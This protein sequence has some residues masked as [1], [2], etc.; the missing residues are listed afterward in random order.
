V[1]SATTTTLPR[2]RGGVL[3]LIASTDH[4]NVAIRIFLTGFFFFVAGGIL[5]LLIRTELYS[6]GQQLVNQDHYNEIFS[7]HGSTMIYLFVV[8]ISL[9]IGVYFVPLQVGAAEIAL[10]RLALLGWWLLIGGGITMWL[11]WFTQ[12]GPGDAGWTA[13]DPLSDATNSPGDGMYLWIIGVML[14]AASGLLLSACIVATITRRR[15]P[16]MTLLRMPVFSWSMLMTAILTIVAMPALIVAMGL[17]FWERVYGGVFDNSGGPIAYQNLFW[18]FGHPIVYVMF[19]PFV[20]AVG[21]VIAVFSRK[22]FFGYRAHVAAMLLFTA[23][24]TSVWAHHMFAT[25]QI[26]V[27]YFSLMSTALII[28]AGIEYL[29]LVATMWGGRIRLGVPMAFALAFILQ[30]LVGGLSGVFIGSPPLDYH[31]TDT[32]FIV[33]HFHY[34]LFAGSLFGFFAAF[35]YWWPKVTGTFLRTGIGWVHFV[36]LF[37]GANLTFFPM[38]FLGYDGMPRRV[39][40]YAPQFTD[41]NRVSTVGAFIIALGILAWLVNIVVSLVRREP[42]PAD[43]W[44]GHTLEWATSSPPP[45][46][47]FDKPL[48][49]IRS[50]APLFDARYGEGVGYPP[51]EAKRSEG[52]EA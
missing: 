6:P 9:A 1:S 38:F 24:S 34:T 17:L 50:Y 18:F 8:P 35:Y 33:G 45:R 48:P 4:K 25:G 10:P 29:D 51:P 3:G 42:A 20:G 21:E 5:A 49:P 14:A 23:L 27:K 41:L 12:N 43:P 2:A 11:G 15:A 22:R 40:D 39:A 36:L 16:G 46:H 30:F 26:T 31:V 47:N 7:M 19:F 32:Y 37:V 13:Y 28:P 44:D 52:R